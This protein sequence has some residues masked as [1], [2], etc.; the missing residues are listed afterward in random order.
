MTENTRR[1][2]R[3][4]V[5][6]MF[7]LT[8]GA[9][10]MVI[11]PLQASSSGYRET[12]FHVPTLLLAIPLLAMMKEMWAPDRIRN[13]PGV[14]VVW[15]LVAVFTLAMGWG[16][17]NGNTLVSVAYWGQTLLPI[18][19]FV[20]GSWTRSTPLAVARGIIIGGLLP[21]LLALT[22]T[23]M[24]GFE[25]ALARLPQLHNILPLAI[26]VG[27]VFAVAYVDKAPNL[28]LTSLVVAALILPGLWSRSSLAFVVVGVGI[29]AVLGARNI[30]HHKRAAIVLAVVWLG[31]I[32]AGVAYQ[33]TQGGTMGER[34]SAAT[35][36][37]AAEKRQ[38]IYQAAI[39]RVMASPVV[40]DA[41]TTVGNIR[42]S[43]GVKAD[44][45]TLFPT[46]NQYLDYAIRAGVVAAF[47]LVLLLFGTARRSL[48]LARDTQSDAAAFGRATVAVVVA[49]ALA[50]NF[51]LFMV[52]G[53]SA[54]ILWFVLGYA[55]R[56]WA[57]ERDARAA[58]QATE[59]PA[60][61]P[62][63]RRRALASA[64]AGASADARRPVRLR[65]EDPR[66]NA[67]GC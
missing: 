19:A 59:Q 56:L 8:V 1:T 3:I 55:N 31:V 29:A 51:H 25:G 23:Y 13:I 48:A 36:G 32:A 22:L 17:L 26:F 60:A 58:E 4:P 46:E 50:N 49:A 66:R 30:R 33:T 42:L 18:S 28:A 20:L 37:M 57:Q 41:F 9:S 10:S 61:L 38:A 16:M 45:S 5:L 6:L 65:L 43:S 64:G 63:P 14:N 44:F 2:A 15:M 54:V 53:Q 39:D 35:L 11:A 47:L 21:A 34:E 7:P 52:Q 24:V 12:F 27:T 67:H 40:G 62:E